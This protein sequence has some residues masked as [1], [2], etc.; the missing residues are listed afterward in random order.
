M[1]VSVSG[2]DEFDIGDFGTELADAQTLLGL[3][4]RVADSEAA[5]LPEARVQVSLRCPSGFKEQIADEIESQFQTQSNPSRG[6]KKQLSGNP[7]RAK[8]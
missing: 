4:H 2:L 1:T 6:K 5:N 8:G 7:A 3:R